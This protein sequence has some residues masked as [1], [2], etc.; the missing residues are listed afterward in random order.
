M[1][2]LATTIW[3]TWHDIYIHYINRLH[4]LDPLSHLQTLLRDTSALARLG[5]GPA[6]SAGPIDQSPILSTHYVY[7]ILLSLYQ[8][9]QLIATIVTINTLLL[10]GINIQRF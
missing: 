6:A 7:D 10:F 1:A 8:L 5:A 4:G 3:M 9:S 2:G